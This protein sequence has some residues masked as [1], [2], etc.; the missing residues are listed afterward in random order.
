MA[1]RIEFLNPSNLP[2]PVGYSQVAKVRG[3][4]LVF[5]SGQAA[6][7]ATG[8]VVGPGDYTVQA[9]Q[10]FRN[11]DAALR[12]AGGSFHSVVKLTYYLVDIHGLPEIREVRDR[13]I[14]TSRPPASTAVQV[15]RLFRPDLL[16]EI[17]AVA[18]VD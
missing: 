14:D 8:N 17:D 16:L 12:A 1:G 3:G 15:S 2:T 5:V 7:D 4:T 18:R 9:E 6:I 13:Y 11:L 10:T